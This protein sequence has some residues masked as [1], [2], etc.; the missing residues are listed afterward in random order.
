ME[1]YGIENLKLAAVK[2]LNFYDG[3]HDRLKDGNFNLADIIATAA[4]VPQLIFIFN[5]VESIKQEVIDLDSDETIALC[6]YIR[7]NTDFGIEDEKLLNIIV[8]AIDLLGSTYAKF[9]ALMAEIK[10]E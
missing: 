4:D 10:G 2:L 5:N 8:A 6:D 7:E 1:N 3:I 9:V